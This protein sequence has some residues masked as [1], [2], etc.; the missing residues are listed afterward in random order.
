MVDG[1]AIQSLLRSEPDFAE[2]L[3]KLL[4]ARLRS[5]T[6]KGA[7]PRSTASTSA[8]WRCWRIG[9]HRP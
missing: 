7:Q 9:D 1:E 5:V 2:A 6:R 4:I 3:V 8:P